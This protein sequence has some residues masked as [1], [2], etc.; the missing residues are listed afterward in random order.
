[1]L[2]Q[3]GL[4]EKQMI[5]YHKVLRTEV[6]TMGCVHSEDAGGVDGGTCCGLTSQVHVCSQ[7]TQA[8]KQDTHISGFQRTFYSSKQEELFSESKLQRGQYY[9]LKQSLFQMSPSLD[10]LLA[11]GVRMV[12]VGGTVVF[13]LAL[14]CQLRLFTPYKDLK[15][16]KLVSYIHPNHIRK[17]LQ[18]IFICLFWWA[19]NHI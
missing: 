9:L 14:L 4:D 7:G 3:Q 6:Q 5:Y 12:G 16:F 2:I 11:R 19:L 1:M 8:I 17:S 10:F 15:A 18:D 13:F